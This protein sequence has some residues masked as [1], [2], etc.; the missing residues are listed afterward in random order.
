MF[1]FSGVNYS[2]QVLKINTKRFLKNIESV[3]VIIIINDQWA[4][5]KC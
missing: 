1:C 4:I 3:Y 5:E 2:S